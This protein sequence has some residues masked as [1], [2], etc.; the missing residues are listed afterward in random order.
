MA[1]QDGLSRFLIEIP[2]ENNKQECLKAIGI[3]KST[4]SHFLSNADWGCVDGTHKAWIMVDVEN[5]E[6]ALN[7]V[8]PWYRNRTTVT[9][10][11][12]LSFDN[13]QKDLAQHRD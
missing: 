2:H 5:K 1:E 13:F 9:K 11:E 10:L 12:K 3:F 4:G 7:I 6:E 8:P